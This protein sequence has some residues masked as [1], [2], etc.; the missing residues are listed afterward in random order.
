ERCRS[1]G[2]KVEELSASY[3]GGDDDRRL[4]Q[5]HFELK[6]A[7]LASAVYLAAQLVILVGLPFV[8]STFDP[9]G[10]PGLLISVAVWFVGGIVVGLVSPGKTF[11]EPAVGALIAVIPTVTYL[12][13]TTPDGFQPSLLAYIVTAL[14]GVMIALFG[15]FIGEKLQMSTRPARPSPRRA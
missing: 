13:I 10:L 15:A 7:L 9:Q 2:A 3:S 14:L 8:I 5:D 1:C 4:Q 11:V 6:W 12:A